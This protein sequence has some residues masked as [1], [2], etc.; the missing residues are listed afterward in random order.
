[1]W[2]QTGIGTA[3]ELHRTAVLLGTGTTGTEKMLES[4]L[5]K[6]QKLLEPELLETQ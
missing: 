4:E 1:M 2:F 5:Q 3:S 6:L